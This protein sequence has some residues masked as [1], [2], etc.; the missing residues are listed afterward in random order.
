[1]TTE[2]IDEVMGLYFR[3]IL[4]PNKGDIVPQH[5]H[6]YDHVSL[7]AS[8]KVRLTVEGRPEGDFEA[9]RAIVIKANKLHVFEALENNTRLA[10]VHQLNGEQYSLLKEA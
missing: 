3:A 5:I 9:F 10:C 1:M 8:G 4:L 6:N 7:I 2:Y